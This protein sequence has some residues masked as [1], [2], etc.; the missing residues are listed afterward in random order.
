MQITVDSPWRALWIERKVHGRPLLA[1]LCVLCILSGTRAGAQEPPAPQPVTAAELQAAVNKLG[2]LDYGI[3]TAASRTIRRTAAS[4]AVPALF[5]AVAE[6]RDGY[7]RYRALVLLTGFNDPRIKDSI[8][9][10]LH[11]P[12]DRLRSVAYSFFEHH[13]DRAMIPDFLGA[14]DREQGEFVRPSLVRALAAQGDEP[15]VRQALLG[16]VGRGANFFRSAVIEA[17]GDYKAGYAFDALTA[18]ARLDGPLQNDAA[19]ALGQIGDKRALQT[20]AALQRTAPRRYQP[21]VAAGICLL[22]V[23]CQTHE[24]YLIDTLKFADQNAGFQELLRSAA[25]GL[26]R[27]ALAGHSEALEALFEIGIPAK[28]DSTRAPVALALGTIALRN[29]PVMLAALSQHPNQKQATELLAEGFDM[30][31]EDLDKEAFFATVRR[32]YWESAERSTRR[33]LMQ[34]LIGKL[35]F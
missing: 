22:G 35:D 15:R 13:P 25:T 26:G 33:Q 1:T 14:L 5:Q 29:T 3:R 7:V 16:E 23:N 30:L 17:L 20:F 4:Q 6:H 27:L 18:I 31:E 24:K 28:D 12:N 2:D 10:S 34:A 11:S 8:R 9:E 19:L 21:T 32:T